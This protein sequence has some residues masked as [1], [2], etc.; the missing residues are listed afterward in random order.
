MPSIHTG[1]FSLLSF[2]AYYITRFHQE[3]D[4]QEAQTIAFQQLSL[5]LQTLNSNPSLT[6]TTLLT[7]SFMRLLLVVHFVAFPV[8]WGALSTSQYN[9]LEL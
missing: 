8:V 2:M 1:I 6:P 7:T 9:V 5:G 4:P 3:I